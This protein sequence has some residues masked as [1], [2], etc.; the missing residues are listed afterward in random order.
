MEPEKKIAIAGATGYT[1]QELVRILAGHPSVKIVALT[2]R[3]DTGQRYEDLFPAF[4]GFGLPK[5]TRFHAAKT[6]ASADLVFFCLPHGNSQQAVAAAA[7][8]G[9]KA[10]DLSADFRLKKPSDY[11]KF[12]GE[13][14]RPDLLKK[15]VYGMPELYRDRIR[16]AMLVANPG[17]Y[18]TGAILGARPFL[19]AGAADPGRVIADMKSGASGAGRKADLPLSFCEVNEGFRAYNLYSHRHR[20][21]MDQE[22]K[23]AAAKKVSV[24]FTPHLAPMNRGIFGTIYLALNKKHTNKALQRILEHA[25]R[26]EPFIRVL[27]GGELPCVSKVRGTNFLDIS[28]TASP[29]GRQAVVCTA[30]DNLVKGASGAAVQNMNLMLGLPETQGLESAPQRP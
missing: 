26:D 5:I 22:L 16:K 30:L 28:V 23:R 15:A 4:R 11:R 9:I 1:G 2:S 3:K 25:Y 12:Y 19:E 6:T 13:H 29:D 24:T 17:C 27:P 7:D 14:K 8:R 21:E 10:V 18:S 20:P